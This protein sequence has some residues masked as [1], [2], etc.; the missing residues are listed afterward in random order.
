VVTANELYENQNPWALLGLLP[1]VPSNVR[2][3]SGNIVFRAGNKVSVKI[4]ENISGV[5]SRLNKAQ[6]D[7]LTA[8]LAKAKTDKEAQ[9]I[10]EQF[11]KLADEESKILADF[12][13]SA[14]RIPGE[15]WKNLEQLRAY[16]SRQKHIHPD[17]VGLI[18][19][20]DSILNGM[21][22][23]MEDGRKLIPNG[24]YLIKDGRPWIILR[25]NAT[26]REVMHEIGHMLA[27]KH[28]GNDYRTL[29]E[30]IRE[31]L[32]AI[33]YRSKVSNARKSPDEI[34]QE[35]QSISP[36]FVPSD[37]INDLLRHWGAIIE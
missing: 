21:S 20:G 27:E 24:A 8:K 16:L 12:T 6:L 13:A 17:G 15:K 22:K 18:T 25:S 37:E 1:L 36:S 9:Q 3:A 4:S 5:L 2:N 29:D 34:W 7:E 35:L 10:L 28:L 26:I 19:T 30:P 23:T 14:A 11:A 33:F 32:A 31:H